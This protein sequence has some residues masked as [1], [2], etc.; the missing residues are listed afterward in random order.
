MPTYPLKSKIILVINKNS[1]LAFAIRVDYI[2]KSSLRKEKSRNVKFCP[3]AA[4]PPPPAAVATP[5]VALSG[6]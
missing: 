6:V 2:K 5:A 4:S 3:F 1:F